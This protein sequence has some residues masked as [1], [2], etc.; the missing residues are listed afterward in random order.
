MSI[1]KPA[2]IERVHHCGSTPEVVEMVYCFSHKAPL[3]AL[4]YNLASVLC[5]HKGTET[6]ESHRNPEG[7]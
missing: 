4:C 3:L 5:P 1:K 2:Q 6:S 7:T